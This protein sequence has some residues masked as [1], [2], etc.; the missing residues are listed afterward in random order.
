[1][2]QK[3]LQNTCSEAELVEFWRLMGEVSED[4]SVTEEIKEVWSRENMTRHKTTDVEWENVYD[5]IMS[6]ARN[7]EIMNSKTERRGLR[8]VWLAAASVI[9]IAGLG[10]GIYAIVNKHIIPSDIYAQSADIPAP[11]MS[12]ATITLA[13]GSTVFLD[14]LSSG[15]V[16]RQDNMKVVKL[17]NGEITYQTG[18]GDILKEMKYN[19]LSNPRG[20]K[21][22]NM[23]LA[24]G[25]KV[26]LNAG[27]SI[28]YPVAFIEKNRRV[29]LEG[30]GYFEISR[31]KSKPF[32]V[33]TGELEVKVL[34]THF[35]VNAY[36]DNDEIRT[37]LL[38][39]SVM[40]NVS[41]QSAIL[42]PGQQAEL[43]V[44][45]GGH[46][47]VQKLRTTDN[48][49]V[50]QVLAWKNG[51]FSFQDAGLKDIMQQISRWYDVDVSY[52]GMIAPR[53]FGG[54]IPRNSDLKTVLKILEASNVHFRLEGKDGRKL[55]VI[56]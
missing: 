40:V 44:H 38:E 45:T 7:V 4:D 2:F 6:K 9:L 32:Y 27:S 30:E 56:P 29:S 36:R 47:S 11:E 15:E 1:M 17:A 42:K 14:S 5:E 33:K 37:T 55:I 20:S 46:G 49:D 10:L 54:V 8:K 41:G 3:Y 18:F 43:P 21:V 28:T 23:T 53:Q 39:G 25:S 50:E 16:A 51:F 24:D 35:N 19:T 52:E 48:V 12:R 13:D 31:N 22:I 26:W 34:G